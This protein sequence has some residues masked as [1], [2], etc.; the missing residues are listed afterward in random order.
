M[1]FKFNFIN[2]DDY[3]EQ[4][5]HTPPHES[6][7][8]AAAT[9]ETPCKDEDVRMECENQQPETIV[10]REEQTQPKKEENQ[11]TSISHVAKK[12]RLEAEASS[13]SSEISENY[14]MGSSNHEKQ[15]AENTSSNGDAGK[16][17]AKPGQPVYSV[18]SERTSWIIIAKSKE[19]MNRVD[20]SIE[21]ER[22]L[23]EDAKVS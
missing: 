18:S 13:S 16:R 17:A 22:M 11:E 6:E 2:L 14:S 4:V 20:K 19:D 9:C 10:E 12:P 5:C 1:F 21:S 15:V 7:T 3:E 8:Y 23:N